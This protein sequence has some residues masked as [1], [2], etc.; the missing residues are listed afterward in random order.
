MRVTGGIDWIS[1]TGDDRTAMATAGSQPAGNFRGSGVKDWE[2][3]SNR[4]QLQLAKVTG[5]A[6]AFLKHVDTL[7][8]TDADN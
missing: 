4:K 2:S 3:P 8:V 1:T 5:A 7:P 6:N